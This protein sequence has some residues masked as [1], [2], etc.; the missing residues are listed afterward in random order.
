[1]GLAASGLIGN[2]TRNEDGFIALR[3]YRQGLAGLPKMAARPAV[4]PLPPALRPHPCV[5]LSS[6]GS[7]ARITPALGTDNI[8]QSGYELIDFGVSAPTASP[9]K[10]GA[11]HPLVTAGEAAA[12][13]TLNG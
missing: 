10:T 12:D 7:G 11:V 6:V 1:M 3:G 4:Y 2:P 8:T 13:F 5:A 9:H